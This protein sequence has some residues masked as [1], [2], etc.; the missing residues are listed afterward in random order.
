MAD[1]ERD[2]ASAYGKIIAKPSGALSDEQLDHAA[3]GALCSPGC[4]PSQAPLT[5]VTYR[6]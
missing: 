2:K 4:G 1:E 6:D 5:T 3:G